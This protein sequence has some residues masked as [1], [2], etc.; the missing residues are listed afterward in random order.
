[1]ISLVSLFMSNEP[2]GYERTQ[3]AM[4][5]ALW[6]RRDLLQLCEGWRVFR[7]RNRA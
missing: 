2:L 6:E 5:S 3:Y 1:M 7:I 4:Q